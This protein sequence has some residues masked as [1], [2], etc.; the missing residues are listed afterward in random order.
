MQARLIL[1][2]NLKVKIYLIAVITNQKFIYN[3]QNLITILIITIITIIYCS[4]MDKCFNLIMRLS[5]FIF[6]TEIKSVTQVALLIF[7]KVTVLVAH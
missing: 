2:G 7:L 1:N 6:K 4:F 5:N 3:P